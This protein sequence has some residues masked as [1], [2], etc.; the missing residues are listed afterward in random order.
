MF[1]ENSLCFELKRHLAKS[2]TKSTAQYNFWTK[3]SG[4]PQCVTGQE[5]R[6]FDL[7]V[8]A[9]QPMQA[10]LG[11]EFDRNFLRAFFLGVSTGPD[12]STW[13]GEETTFLS[14]PCTVRSSNS[15]PGMEHTITTS[16][17]F[18]SIF[19]LGHPFLCEA[20]HGTPM[21]KIQWPQLG[22]FSILSLLPLTSLTILNELEKLIFMTF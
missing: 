5:R 13:T 4:S 18:F 12:Y 19:R 10:G 8:P 7:L 16:R 14:S 9:S 1:F 11:K 20:W 3:N 22:R 6:L 17:P 2:L 15:R 21:K